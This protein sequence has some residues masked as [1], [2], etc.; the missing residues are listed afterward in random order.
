MTSVQFLTTEEQIA[1]AAS[2]LAGFPTGT[3]LLYVA[4]KGTVRVAFPLPKQ[5]FVRTPKFGA[6]K[7]RDLHSLVFSRPEYG[8]AEAIQD[9]RMH[10]VRTL[11]RHLSLIF[12]ERERQ[13]RR[14]LA[15]SNTRT[16]VPTIIVNENENHDPRSPL[17]I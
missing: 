5:P 9:A 7:V 2:A 10:F 16:N 15:A 3:A 4:G 1:Q 11:A 6:K 14:L 17:A 8:S 12:E 13:S